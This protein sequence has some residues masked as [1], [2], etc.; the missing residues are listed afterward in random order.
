MIAGLTVDGGSVSGESEPGHP[1]APASTAATEAV[2]A[3]ATAAPPGPRDE[4]AYTCNTEQNTCHCVPV[5]T[6]HRKAETCTTQR[7]DFLQT[8][9]SQDTTSVHRTKKCVMPPFLILLRFRPAC[10]LSFLHLS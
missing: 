4:P 7:L 2:Q 6:L 9:L 3:A 5:T 10:F 1:A 8:A